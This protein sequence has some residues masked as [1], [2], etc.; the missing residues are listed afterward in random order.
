MCC[1]MWGQHIVNRDRAC[2]KASFPVHKNYFK[3]DHWCE[4]TMENKIPKIQWNHQTWHSNKRQ[5]QDHEIAVYWWSK[6]LL[7]HWW[8]KRTVLTLEMNFTSNYGRVAIHSILTG[9]V[10]VEG[11]N[12]SSCGQIKS[13]IFVI[14]LT[15]VCPNV[16][17]N[18]V[19]TSF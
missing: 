8:H 10:L 18:C 9:L 5:Q 14:W 16:P 3:K 19:S 13:L 12:S 11:E 6:Q 4:Q 17:S 1:L 7:S 15:L 2:D